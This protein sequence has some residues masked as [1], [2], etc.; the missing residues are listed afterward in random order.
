MRILKHSLDGSVDAFFQPATFVGLDRAAR[1]GP[2]KRRVMMSGVRVS[3][4]RYEDILIGPRQGCTQAARQRGI[5]FLH[6]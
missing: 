6:A 5:D 1:I 3:T 2:G 4:A